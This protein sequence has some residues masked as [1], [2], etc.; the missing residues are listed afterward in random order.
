MRAHAL[1]RFAVLALLAALATTPARAGARFGL[2]AG[3]NES[4]ATLDSEFGPPEPAYR[5]AWSARLTLDVQLAPRF[6]IAT[7]LRYLEYGERVT[8]S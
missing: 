2:E 7:G 1:I 6:S 8:V 3:L 4:K 5:P